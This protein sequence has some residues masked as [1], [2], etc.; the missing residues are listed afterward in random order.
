MALCVTITA[1]G[2]L[3]ATGEAVESCAGYVMVSGSEYSTQAVIDRLLGWPDAETAGG[4]LVGSFAFVFGS[5]VIAR[6]VGSVVS[7][8]NDK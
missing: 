2:T 6:L 3:V 7:M 1:S 5:F 8:F 4:W